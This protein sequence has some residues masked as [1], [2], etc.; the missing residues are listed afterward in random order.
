MPTPYKSSP[1]VTVSLSGN[2]LID[3][4]IAGRKWA[5]DSSGKFVITYSF[6]TASS[7][8]A[9]SDTQFTSALSDNAKQKARDSLKAW[10]DV[11]NLVFVEVEETPTLVGDIRFAYGTNPN[12]SSNAVG[13]ASFPGDYPG[14]GDV[15][16]NQSQ[17]KYDSGPFLHE[18]GH[19]LGLKHPFDGGIIAPKEFDN[20]G[21]SVL[22]YTAREKTIFGNTPMPN[23]I[24]AIQYLYGTNMST[25][26]GNDNYQ[27]Q[28]QSDPMTGYSNHA[29]W[30]AGG[31]DTFDASLINK[32]V[33][34]DLRPG[35]F[36]AIGHWAD[37]YNVAIPSNVI[38]ENAVASRFD[39]IIYD[40]EA[41]NWLEGG[42]G[43][44][45]FYVG[46]GNDT[47]SGGSGN[48]TIYYTTSLKAFK[49]NRVEDSVVIQGMNN[50]SNRDVAF[51]VETLRFSD[52][53]VNLSIQANAKLISTQNLRTLEELYV[54]FFNRV[55]DA[56][57]LNY[58]IK[59]IQKGMNIAQIAESFYTAALQFSKET[60]Y[61]ESATN[62]DFVRIIYKNVLG[63]F[64]ETAPPDADVNYWATNLNNGT[65]SRGQLV[66]SMLLSAH[67]YKGDKTWGWVADL[68]DN[69]VSVANYFALQNG[70]NF[71]SD[72]ESI[73]KGMA[74]A[75]Q[76]NAT[77]INAA[78]QLI[79][80]S[81]DAITI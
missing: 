79:G 81:T 2:I 51:S 6:P 35:G 10:S 56:D 42:E 57:G 18:L 21:Y 19:A 38:I 78:I 61:T 32:A 46:L 64:A 77:D 54:A 20:L 16:T 8:W 7:L 67:T 73:S 63:R 14:A 60:G 48:D 31:V 47:I 22:S 12:I 26:A 3:S 1:T 76:V 52:Y 4:L 15:W 40:N 49:V 80:L 62:T 9:P 34:I 66:N 69:K 72:Q 36:S 37:Y 43:N 33:V 65:V 53:S 11:C 58:W 59:Q 27:F 29:Y 24:L 68:L 50:S 25:H 74:I 13:W 30:D 55:P 41:D 70:L 5:P 71:N 23:D 39:D 28:N 44:D 17:V 45:Q 75:S